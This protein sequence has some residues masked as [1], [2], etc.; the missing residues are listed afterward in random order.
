MM[1]TWKKKMPRLV[2]HRI[3]LRSARFI[4]INLSLFVCFF[5]VYQ[6]YWLFPGYARY[7]S[8]MLIPSSNHHKVKE[9]TE[10]N[11]VH[12]SKICSSVKHVHINGDIS[13]QQTV[14]VLCHSVCIPVL[15]R[16]S[17]IVYPSRIELRVDQGTR[18]LKVSLV[19]KALFSGVSC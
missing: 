1:G 8:T 6:A 11:T 7:H 17:P 19:F 16:Y 18:G 13:A 5:D 2:F 3:F 9:Y 4:K 12:E 14:E 15:E 10:Y